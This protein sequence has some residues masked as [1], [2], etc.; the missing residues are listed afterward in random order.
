MLRTRFLVSLYKLCDP[1]PIQWIQCGT[2][3]LLHS[4]SPFSMSGT[5]EMVSII[6]DLLGQSEDSVMVSLCILV[7]IIVKFRLRLQH[8]VVATCLAQ[9]EEW[10]WKWHTHNTFVPPLTVHWFWSPMQ[11]TSK[12][13][14]LEIDRLD[15]MEDLVEG[16][17]YLSGLQIVKGWW[18]F[19]HEWNA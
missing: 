17:G 5:D 3:L 11:T 14:S 19:S 7:M 4:G 10:S 13:C 2:V 9:K 6:M 12:S 15:H 18:I 16:N 1:H 8:R